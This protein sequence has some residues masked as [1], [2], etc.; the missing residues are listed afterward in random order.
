MTDAG[1]MMR[2]YVNQYN[3]LKHLHYLTLPE[4][5]VGYLRKLDSS[6]RIEC[7]E[8]LGQLWDHI[9]SLM[10]EADDIPSDKSFVL[11]NSTIT[12]LV[13]D[14][15]NE[16]GIEYKYKT[17]I[18]QISEIDQDIHNLLRYYIEEILTYKTC[19]EFQSNSNLKIKSDI[20]YGLYSKE[21]TMSVKVSH[22]NGN[23]LILST[24]Q[25]ESPSDPKCN[26]I[27]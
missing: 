14:N 6:K 22:I 25:I 20:K 24:K 9:L 13:N 8:I 17:R 11:F 5:N 12:P 4:M 10:I 26:Q 1:F 16:I 27:S 2:K 3:L 19:E 21:R 15:K 7:D 18:E 23:K